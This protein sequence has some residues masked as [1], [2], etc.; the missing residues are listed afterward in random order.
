MATPRPASSALA[1]AL[2]FMCFFFPTE[3]TERCRDLE[4]GDEG[5]GA[6]AALAEQVRG[7]HERGHGELGSSVDL[8]STPG[9]QG[10]GAQRRC[11]DGIRDCRQLLGG[12][13]RLSR[14]TERQSCA[15]KQL[16][17]GDPHQAIVL[18]NTT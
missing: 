17:R 2:R 1:P 3:G 9:K 14:P 4:T 18:A 10:G 11:A 6:H 12:P 7:I 5:L 13:L 16:E 15:D 8:D